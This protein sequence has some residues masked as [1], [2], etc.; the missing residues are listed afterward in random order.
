ME[1]RFNDRRRNDFNRGPPRQM[2]KATCDECKQECE[3]PFKPTQGKPVYCRDCF[4]K[5]A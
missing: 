2:H 5:R 1:K 4:R 3:V